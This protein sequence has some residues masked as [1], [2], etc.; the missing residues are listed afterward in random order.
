MRISGS[1]SLLTLLSIQVTAGWGQQVSI[2]HDDVELKKL[3]TDAV[4]LVS[5]AIVRFSYG[6]EPRYRFGCGVIVSPDGH[7]AVSGPVH[8][9]ID[10]ELLELRLTD[11]RIVKGEA[12]GWS[13][14]FGFGL[15]KITEAGPWP[16]VKV[17]HQPKVGLVCVALGYVRNTDHAVATEPDVR[18]G[19]VTKSSRGR[20]LTTSHRTQFNSHPVFDLSGKLLGLCSS[21]PVGGD[22]IHASAA[23]I[24]EHW[25]DFVAGKNLDRTRL[26]PDKQEMTGAELLNAKAASVR[27]SNV[28]G[29]DKKTTASGTIVTE[30]GYVITCGH[31]ARIPGEKL[32]VSLGD[33]RSEMATVLGTNFVCDVG[34]LKITNDGPWPHVEMGRS[35]GRDIGAPC[36]LLGYPKSRRDQDTWA[37]RTKIIKPTQTLSRRDEWYDEFWTEKFPDSIQGASG[38]GVFDIDGRVIG[39]LLGGAGQEMQHARIELFLK[40]WN[41]LIA[42]RPVQALDAS[43]LEEAS[44]QLIRIEKELTE[45]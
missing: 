10:N 9:V 34:V 33:G 28:L 3:I 19:L 35:A 15:L 44:T 42:N 39:V 37:F 25:D 1:I 2:Q 22:E 24:T 29:D 16:H 4:H 21:S 30:D 23:L 6:K 13:S 41:T 20:W 18:L 17:N 27:I 40:N 7:I 38:G 31:H 5:P 26:F 43:F 14:E 45:K 8:A 36:V 12:L 32:L 11:G